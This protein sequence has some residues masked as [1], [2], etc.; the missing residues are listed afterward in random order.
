MPGIFQEID[1]PGKRSYHTRVSG[2]LWNVGKK[3]TFRAG[4]KEI[5][6]FRPDTY[7]N[8]LNSPGRLIKLV[9]SGLMLPE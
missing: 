9:L 4:Q 1:A 8:E 7:R 6:P 5:D 2:K 3:K